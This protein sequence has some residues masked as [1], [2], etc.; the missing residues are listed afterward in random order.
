MDVP[1][2][3][4]TLS[5]CSMDEYQSLMILQRRVVVD[6]EYVEGA[7]DFVPNL[8]LFVDAKRY[9]QYRSIYYRDEIWTP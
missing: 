3:A 5:S 2:V 1:I 8:S 7:P 9:I 6:L 4:G